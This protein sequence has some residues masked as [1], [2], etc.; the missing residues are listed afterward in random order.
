MAEKSRATGPLLTDLTYAFMRSGQTG[1]E[2]LPSRKIFPG[3]FL[4]ANG[5][6]L[7]WAISSYLLKQSQ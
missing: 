1:A 3:S 4:M 7:S 6:F 2:I 5:G